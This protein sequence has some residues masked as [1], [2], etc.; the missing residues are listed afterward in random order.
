[1]RFLQNFTVTRSWNWRSLTTTLHS[2]TSAG[3][4]TPHHPMDE[5][6]RHTQA[7]LLS[8]LLDA[9][10]FKCHL[11]PGASEI[12]TQPIANL[13]S[14]IAKLG[15]F[16]ELNVVTSTFESLVCQISENPQLS[17][18]DIL[19]SLWGV[20]VCCARLSLVPNANKNNVF[21]KHMDDLF[22]RTENTFPGNEEEQTIIAMAASWLGK[23]CP[24]VPHYRTT[25]SETQTDFHDQL[26]SRIPS[27]RIKKKKKV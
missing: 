1:M 23:P 24:F 15:E 21:E 22:T 6:V 3:A 18:Q 5:G 25:M 14:S 10:I 7:A 16:V 4:F 27:L 8:T 20:M 13:L 2:F 19:M 17:Q 26:Q 12:D 11:Q 9:I